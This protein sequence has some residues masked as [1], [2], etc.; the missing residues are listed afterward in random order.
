MLAAAAEHVPPFV[1]APPVELALLGA[2]ARVG[3]DLPTV[4][5]WGGSAAGEEEEEERGG[6]G[7]GADE[8]GGGGGVE[9]FGVAILVELGGG[10]KGRA[11]DSGVRDVLLQV[12]RTLVRSGAFVV[13]P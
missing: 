12:A 11:L 1:S 6:G 9:G 5:G 2:A 7:R 8:Y 3:G 10:N 13:L 4:V